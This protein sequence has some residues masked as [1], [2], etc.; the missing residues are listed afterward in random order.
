MLFKTKSYN[1]LSEAVL[2]EGSPSEK[3]NTLTI[4]E[5][6]TPALDDDEKYSNWNA[7]IKRFRYKL[8]E[9][10]ANGAKNIN[11]F[12]EFSSTLYERFHPELSKKEQKIIG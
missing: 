10:Y 5:T 4:T 3:L 7:N 11:N 12:K 2:T 6:N 8:D 1:G 9:N